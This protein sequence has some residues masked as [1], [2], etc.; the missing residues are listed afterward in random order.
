MPQPSI[1]TLA[2]RAVVKIAGPEARGFLK[3]LL[4]RDAPEPGKAAF[5]ALLTPQGKILFDFLMAGVED[6][7]LLD[8][9]AGSADS[10]VKRLMLY[11]LRAKVTIERLAGWSAAVSVDAG[12]EAPAES[13]RF[14]D[15]RLLGLGERLIGPALAPGGA[16]PEADYD[17]RRIGLGVPEFGKDFGPEEVFLLDVNYDALHGVDYKKGCFVGQEVTSR[18]KRKGEVRKRTVRLSFDGPPPEKGADVTAGGAQLGAVLSG[19]EGMALALLRLDRI[20]AAAGADILAGGRNVR[21][22]IP[23]YLERG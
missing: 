22:D 2:S 20:E 9:D 14:P 3:G 5:A 15:P 6:G 13:I 1:A 11:R 12:G 8:C 19:A 16:A 17:R 21:V 4:T 10:L 23:A 18:M 7:V